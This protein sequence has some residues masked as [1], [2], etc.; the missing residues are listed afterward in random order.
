MIHSTH[1]NA[2]SR[3]RKSAPI[4]GLCVIGFS[5]LN[6]NSSS[7]SLSFVV[8]IIVDIVVVVNVIIVV[9]IVIVKT[10]NRNMAATQKIERALM[11]SYRPSIV[12]FPLS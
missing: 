3:R 6:E 11:T 7:S 5:Y 2:E 4:S 12:T 10:G 8:V 9:V 1:F